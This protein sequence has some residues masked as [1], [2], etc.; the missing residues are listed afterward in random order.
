MVFLMVP[1][2]A[3]IDKNTAD[4]LNKL[5]DVPLRLDNP[6]LLNG[7]VNDRQQSVSIMGN[8][9]SFTYNDGLYTDAALHVGNHADT[10]RCAVDIVKHM[11]DGIPYS[12]SLRAGAADN[13][14]NASFKWENH[15]DNRMSG[16]LNTASQFFLAPNGQHTG[17]IN[18]L[19]SQITIQ[20]SSG[21]TIYED[22][23]N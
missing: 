21:A 12:L 16:T 3:A 20:N 10:L 1:V 22:T 23:T 2:K 5:L 6:L 19:P 4:W 8:C 13:K 18:V 17:V 11:D 14:L 9:P 15:S 7:F